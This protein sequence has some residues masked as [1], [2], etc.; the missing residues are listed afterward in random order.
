MD[1]IENNAFQLTFDQ[2]NTNTS[3]SIAILDDDMFEKSV[4]TFVV[5]LS[6]NDPRVRLEC[7]E[8]T[9]SIIDD[10]SK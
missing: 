1:F 8:T 9:I 7:N 3:I 5:L 4:E 6:T 2:D 10:D